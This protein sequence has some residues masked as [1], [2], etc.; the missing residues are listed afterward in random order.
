MNNE[1]ILRR[2]VLEATRG[3]SVQKIRLIIT[4]Y[5]VTCKN[6]VV[7]WQSCVFGG[8]GATAGVCGVA[9]G[10][11]GRFDGPGGES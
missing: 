11:F 9:G 3:V 6:K 2:T 5:E 10:K 4:Y 1:F 8:I 7:E